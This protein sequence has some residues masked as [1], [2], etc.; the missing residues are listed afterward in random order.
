MTSVKI[1]LVKSFLTF[2]LIAILSGC[3]TTGQKITT[4]E[5]HNKKKVELPAEVHRVNKDK[6]VKAPTV[7]LL[8]GCSGPENAN[9]QHWIKSLNSWGYNAVVINSISPRGTNQ[10]C[11][12]PISVVTYEQRSVDAYDT[13]KWV[14]QQEWATDKVGIIGFSH[15]GASVLQSVAAKT[16]ERNLGKQIIAAGVAYY[17]YC[18]S[19]LNWDKPAIPIQFHTG[20]ADTWTPASPCKDLAKSWKVSDQYFEY[21]AATHGFDLVGYNLLSIPDANRKSHWLIYNREHTDLSRQ[22]TKSF[23]DKYLK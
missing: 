22:R 1:S 15:G 18:D 2:S 8:H 16:I 4:T 20:G 23:L 12:R 6:V 3:V 13:A 21:Q 10:I 19:F 5:L 17:P 9:F 7:I 11:D 14:I